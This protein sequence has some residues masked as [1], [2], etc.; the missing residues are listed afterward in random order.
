MPL[1][2]ITSPQDHVVEPASSEHLAADVGG[3]VEHRWLERS[4][5]VAT[6]L[7]P[8]PDR[9]RGRRRSPSKVVGRRPLASP[10]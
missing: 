5:H 8:G 1:L 3:P 10:P 7:R 9:R 2:L 4:Y 6:G